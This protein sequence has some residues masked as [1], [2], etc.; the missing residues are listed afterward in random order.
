MYPKDA[1]KDDFDAVAND[2][3]R[4]EA[5]AFAEFKADQAL[6]ALDHQLENNPTVSTPT[7]K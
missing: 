6:Q 5:A 7:G 3:I 2:F 4:N 1:F